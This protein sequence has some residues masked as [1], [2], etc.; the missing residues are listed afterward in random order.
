MLIFFLKRI[1]VH[2]SVI[3]LHPLLIPLHTLWPFVHPPWSSQVPFDVSTK[4][5]VQAEQR[6]AFSV[7]CLGV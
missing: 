5:T 4:V 3:L 2:P 6:S 1:P 7:L